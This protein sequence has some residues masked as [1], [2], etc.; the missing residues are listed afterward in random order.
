M[1]DVIYS[2]VQ[3]VQK[4]STSKFFS[5]AKDGGYDEGFLEELNNTLI[6][7]YDNWFL[8][9]RKYRTELTH[10]S[11]GACHQNRETKKIRYARSI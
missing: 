1:K 8:L 5:K 4:I 9:L 7:A 2:S 3:G 10:G 11:L 6:K